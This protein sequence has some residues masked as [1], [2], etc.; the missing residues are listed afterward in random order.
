MQRT[1]RRGERARSERLCFAMSWQHFRF[2]TCQDLGVHGGRRQ[3]Q[4]G[5]DQQRQQSTTIGS[6]RDAQKG[7][8][9]EAA[10]IAAILPI[11]AAR[12]SGRFGMD[13]PGEG[14]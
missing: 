6:F 10:R 9:G 13:R 4:R 1:Q 2:L 14:C 7:L 3:R 5:Y 11:A 8:R 12:V